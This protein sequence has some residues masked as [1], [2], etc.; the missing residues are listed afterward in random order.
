M[1]NILVEHNEIPCISLVSLTLIVLKRRQQLE[2]LGPDLSFCSDVLT[3]CICWSHVSVVESTSLRAHPT[4]WLSL[5]LRWCSG[6]KPWNMRPDCWW[7]TERLTSTFAA[8]VS[9]AQRK[10][11]SGWA[12][13]PR[14]LHLHRPPVNRAMAQCPNDR[15]SPNPS[16]NLCHELLKRYWSIHYLSTLLK[17]D[18]F[19]CIYKM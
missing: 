12:L 7:L 10:W 3:W 17:E 2:A 4:V 9:P 6:S 1:E 13:Q 16:G 14:P 11:P 19:C 8:C 15:R 5:T 18:F